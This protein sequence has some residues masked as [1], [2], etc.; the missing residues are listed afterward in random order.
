MKCTFKVT[1][2]DWTMEALFTSNQL[3]STCVRTSTPKT[4]GRNDIQFKCDC[5]TTGT[6]TCTYL[7]TSI[8]NPNV[9]S[10]AGFYINS[11]SCAKI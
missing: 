5:V 11:K 3:A 9:G 10:A 2:Q 7:A 4:D 1:L 8:H 6:S